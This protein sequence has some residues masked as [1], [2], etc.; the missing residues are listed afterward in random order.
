MPAVSNTTLLRY[1]I[2]IEQEQLLPKVYGQIFVPR[3]VHEELTHA[4][5]PIKVREFLA[6]PPAWYQIRDALRGLGSPFPLV[7]DRGEQE[8]I[9]LAEF[10]RADVLLIDDRVGRSVARDRNLFISGTIG[11]LE[12]GDALG[13]LSDFPKTIANLKTSGFFLSESLEQEIMY[14]HRLRQRSK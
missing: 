13:F 9:L 7:L 11:V 10:L 8:A 6:A 5:T 14:R 2:A 1:L 3:A 4:R 12:I